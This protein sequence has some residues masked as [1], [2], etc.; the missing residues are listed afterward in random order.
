MPIEVLA[1]AKV[2]LALDILE[3]PNISGGFHKLET[4]FVIT[5]QLTNRVVLAKGNPNFDPNF[6][7]PFKALRTFCEFTKIPQTFNL[8]IIEKIPSASG[9]GGASS[10]AAAVLFALSKLHKVSDDNLMALAKELGMDVPMY[11][12]AHL[13]G[14]SLNNLASLGTNFG[15]KVEIL[16]HLKD[17]NLILHPLSSKLENKT[18]QAFEALNIDLCGQK[19]NDTKKL[20]QL[21]RDGLSINKSF[22]HNDFSQLYPEISSGDFLSGSGPSTFSL[23]ASSAS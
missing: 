6:L 3:P 18:K 16:G 21:I 23:E 5:T 12:N 17:L 20:T 15:E 11:L 19:N 8:E 13:S 14:L 22:L 7:L 10:N 1:P 2:N 4:V 9:L